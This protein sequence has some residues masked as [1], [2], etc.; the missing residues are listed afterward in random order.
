MN[1]DG[2]TITYV[3]EH[4]HPLRTIDVPE[5]PIDFGQHHL[6]IFLANFTVGFVGSVSD[7]WWD[8]PVTG[9]IWYLTELMNRTISATELVTAMNIYGYALPTRFFSI[10]KSSSDALFL[11]KR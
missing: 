5:Q 9:V 11:S 6:Q 10:K 2:A 8:A 1:V 7:S 4:N 3:L